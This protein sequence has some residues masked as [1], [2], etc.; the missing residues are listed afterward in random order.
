M[1]ANKDGS[2]LPD[3]EPEFTHVLHLADGR[4]VGSSG[5]VPTEYSDETGVYR[6]VHV[7]GWHQFYEDNGKVE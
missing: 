6:V 5:A 3:Y 4:L 2:K 1:P 7:T